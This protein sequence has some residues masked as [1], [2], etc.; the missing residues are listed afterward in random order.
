MKV[1]FQWWCWSPTGVLQNEHP[2]SRRQLDLPAET[3]YFGHQFCHRLI[4]GS[5]H[6][7]EFMPKSILDRD[8]CRYAAK[9]D[10]SFSNS[11][12]H[13][14]TWVETYERSPC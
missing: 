4:A 6:S 13:F 14:V 7:T 5:G 12:G 9:C 3:F 11:R 2:Y 1:V 10:G 8:T